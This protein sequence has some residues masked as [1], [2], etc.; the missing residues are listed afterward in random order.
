[1]S[2]CFS[3]PSYVFTALELVSTTNGNRTVCSWSLLMNLSNWL[4]TIGAAK[5]AI[6]PKRHLG[7]DGCCSSSRCEWGSHSIAKRWPIW[8]WLLCFAFF[9]T[10]LLVACESVLLRLLFNF[11]F[12]LR[13]SWFMAVPG[14]SIPL[15]AVLYC[16]IDIRLN[17]CFNEFQESVFWINSHHVHLQNHHK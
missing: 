8:Q 17:S 1:M 16:V 11:T 12:K 9:A 5:S 4:L 3:H 2:S 10:T 6:S 14:L 7:D 13:S 15:N